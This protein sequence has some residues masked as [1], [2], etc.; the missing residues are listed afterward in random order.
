MTPILLEVCA[1][2]HD[3]MEKLSG[4]LLLDTASRLPS[5][6]Y[7]AKLGFDLNHPRFD[8]LRKLIV[9]YL[10]VMTSEYAQTFFKNDE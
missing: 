1:D 2:A 8:S 6:D 3:E 7:L 9:H 4:Q 10:S 5:V